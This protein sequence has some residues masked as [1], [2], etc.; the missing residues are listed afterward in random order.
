[1]YH[2]TDRILTREQMRGHGLVDDGLVLVTGLENEVTTAQHWNAHGCEVV[3][4]NGV[5]VGIHV[6]FG[7]VF[8]SF[9]LV[10]A[11]VRADAEG[12]HS[13]ETYGPHAGKSGDAL[14]DLGQELLGFVVGVVLELGIHG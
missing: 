3:A 5:G 10:V 6:L 11:A 13:D 1:M 8:R 12:N 14:A 9:S 4:T 2:A 7:M